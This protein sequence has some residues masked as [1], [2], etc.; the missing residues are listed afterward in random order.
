MINH[1]PHNIQIGDWVILDNNKENPVRVFSMTTNKL[2]SEVGNHS[3]PI[4][5]WNTMTNRLKPL[6]TEVTNENNRN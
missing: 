5:T 1:N 6:H 2:F 3:S 4:D